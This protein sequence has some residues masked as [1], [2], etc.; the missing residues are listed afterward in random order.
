MK[1]LLLVLAATATL[2]GCSDWTERGYWDWNRERDKTRWEL[3]KDSYLRNKSDK[4]TVALRDIASVYEDFNL[5]MPNGNRIRVCSAYGCTHKQ[6]YRISADTLRKAKSYFS[7]SWTASGERSGLEKALQH[8]ETVMGPA[9]NTAEDA[10]GGP[11]FG[12]GN[13]G[14][15]NHRDEALNTTSILMVM[16]RYGLIRYHDLEAPMWVGG[17]FYPILRD[18]SNGKRYGID[19]GYRSSGGEVKIFAVE[20]GAP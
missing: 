8:I 20:D 7:G 17:T 9:T 5:V 1:K 4:P 18:R 6:V 15:M 16:F 19:T 11:L 10:Q 13:S 12:N 2:V 14:Q 3:E